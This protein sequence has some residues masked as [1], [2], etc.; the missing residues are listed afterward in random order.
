[1]RVGAVCSEFGMEFTHE[2]KT[3][4]SSEQPDTLSKEYWVRA[5]V[6]CL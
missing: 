2:P 6:C 5:V 4:N 3:D 1:M